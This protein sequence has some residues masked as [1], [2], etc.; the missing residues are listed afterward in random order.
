MI[1]FESLRILFVEDN[2]HQA[3][4]IIAITETYLHSR[5]R[6]VTTLAAALREIGTEEPDII[7]L[8]LQLPDARDLEALEGVQRTAPHI[9]IVVLTG[10][11][12]EGLAQKAVV[13]GAQD[14]LCKSNLDPE[15]LRRSLRYAILRHKAQAELNRLR[16]REH[17]D[18]A[19]SLRQMEQL[20]IPEGN[21][22]MTDPLAAAA[23]LRERNPEKFYRLQEHYQYLLCDFLGRIAEGKTI[24]GI[25]R[26]LSLKLAELEANPNDVNDLHLSVLRN[27]LPGRTEE[28]KKSLLLDGRMFALEIMGYL[29]EA[30]RRESLGSRMPVARDRAG[31][32]SIVGP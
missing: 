22:G 16:E 25:G 14:F 5:V 30:Y 23:P 15:L 3:R 12:E 2:F 1:A 10:R 6:H 13:A 18:L 7:L 20:G 31:L 28:E 8:D 4:L 21:G 9:P 26:P 29:A 19:R 17:V 32:L 11:E 27:C 24:F